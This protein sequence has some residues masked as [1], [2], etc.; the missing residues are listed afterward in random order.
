MTSL[1]IAGMPLLLVEHPLGGERAEG[2]SRRA[3]QALE[4]LIG[5]IGHA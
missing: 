2:V 1:G 3:V 5:L 4:Q